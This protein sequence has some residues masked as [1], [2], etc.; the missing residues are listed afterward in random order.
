MNLTAIYAPIRH[1]LEELQELLERELITPDPFIGELV[2]HVLN[3]QGKMI[4]P[5]LVCLS[6]RASGGAAEARLW[7]AA[8]V[9]LIH[10]A[11]LIHDDIIDAADTRRGTP[12]VNVQ[13]GNQI[14]VLLGDFLF[15]KAF[16]LLS[17]VRHPEVSLAMAAASVQM[18]QAEIMQIKYGSQTHDDEAMYFQII[19]G[20]TAHL[21]SAACRAGALAAADRRAADALGTFGQEWGMAFQITDD[22]LDLTSRAEQLGKP[23]HSD[24]RSGKTTLPLIHALRTAVPADRKRLIDLLAAPLRDGQMEEVRQLLGRYRGIEYALD[25]AGGYSRRAAESLTPLAGGPAKDSLLQL[26]EFVVV[27]SR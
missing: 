16:D 21:F 12:T 22:A 5:A 1:D 6:A 11:S 18:S 14:A 27:R 17:R 9:E 20:K 15:A 3:T 4:R 13:W 8:A 24:I 19:S 2:R 10:I 25:V 7:I 23:I 26:T